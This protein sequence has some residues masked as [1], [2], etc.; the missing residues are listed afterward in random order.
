MTKKVKVNGKWVVVKDGDVVSE[1]TPTT[2]DTVTP[3][4]PSPAVPEGEGDVEGDIAAEAQKI[5]AELA[6]SFLGTMGG[7]RNQNVADEV[8]KALGNLMPQD[9]KLKKILGGKDLVRDAASLTKEE[10]IVGFY[11]AL[12][13]NNEY[14]LKALSEGTAADGGYLF[15]NEFMTELVRALPE[16]N[17]MREWVRIIPMKRDVMD[18]STLVSGPK[19]FW[20]AENA[21]KTTT[22]AHFGTDTLTARKLAAILYASDELIE[23][24]DIFD[25]VQLII[26]LFAEEIGREE[27]KVIWT[28]NNTTQPEGIDAANT[29]PT[30]SAGVQTFDALINLYYSL[31]RQYRQNAA[32]FMNDN[33]AKSAAKLKDSTGQYLWQPSVREGEDDT[34]KG[35]P[36]VISNWVPDGKIFFGDLKRAYFL[37]DRKRMTVK[38]SQDTETAFTKD[39]TAIRVVARIA[40]ALV[41]PSAARQITGF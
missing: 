29:V 22:S 40:G 41:L 1:D 11:H 21:A 34:L 12:V 9:A 37:G 4:T 38:V 19:V 7:G 5:G 25:V 24:S 31:P 6:R 8:A 16:F 18:I 14:A 15:P 30:V 20:T 3:P 28:G 32:F 39:Q 2:D 36:V 17:V 27:E 10:K 23:D 33:T 13:T 26:Q 35:K